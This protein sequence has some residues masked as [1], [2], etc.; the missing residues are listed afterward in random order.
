MLFQKYSNTNQYSY[1]EFY[2]KNKDKYAKTTSYLSHSLNWCTVLQKKFHYFYSVLLA[3]NVKRCETILQ[4]R[5]NIL[6]DI[7]YVIKK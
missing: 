1:N 7:V 5:K 3:G 6:F 2:R 4:T